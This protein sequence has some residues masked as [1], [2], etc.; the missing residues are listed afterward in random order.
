MKCGGPKVRANAKYCPTCRVE[1]DKEQRKGINKRYQIKK[2]LIARG[3]I[4]KNPGTS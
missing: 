3:L 1:I 4:P 2:A